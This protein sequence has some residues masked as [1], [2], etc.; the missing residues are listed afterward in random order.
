M[1]FSPIKLPLVLCGMA[2]AA[3]SPNAFA[4]KNDPLFA[5][6]IELIGKHSN[7]DVVVIGLDKTILADSVAKNIGTKYP[8]DAKNEVT[9]TL[10]DGKTRTFVEKSVDYPKGAKET[11]HA[12][13][14]S[15][16][17]IIGAVIVSEPLD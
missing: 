2:F 13:K 9:M 12:V 4:A 17:K 8:H 3:F 5:G 1:K 15:K 10:A 14:N 11:V 7:R 16:G 6:A